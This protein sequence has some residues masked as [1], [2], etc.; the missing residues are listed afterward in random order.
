M[1]LGYSGRHTAAAVELV[2]ERDYGAA[3][4]AEGGDF[5]QVAIGARHG[6]DRAVAVDRV[7]GGGKVPAPALGAFADLSGRLPQGFLRQYRGDGQT[8]QQG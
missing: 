5:L 6:H 2:L 4:T 8:E 7:S 3:V 1:R